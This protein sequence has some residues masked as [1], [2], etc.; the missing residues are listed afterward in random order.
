MVSELASFKAVKI[1]LRDAIKAIKP[2]LIQSQLPHEVEPVAKT[3]VQIPVLRDGVMTRVIQESTGK[4]SV[5]VIEITAP[6]EHRCDR[7]KGDNSDFKTHQELHSLT[8]D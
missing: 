7:Q 2:L 8:H 3:K 5:A 1:F 6:A 4:S